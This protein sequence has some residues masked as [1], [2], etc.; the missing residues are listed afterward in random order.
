M[1]EEKKTE[2]EAP[3]ECGCECGCENE[4]GKNK[5]CCSEKDSK[6][7]K[8]I[9]SL[10]ILLGGL[11]I[12][13][14]FVDVAQM[15]RGSGFSTKNLNRSEIFQSEGKTWVAYSEPAVP[16][17]VIND[18]SC[19]KCDVSDALV[20]M[21]RIVPTISTEKVDYSSAKGKELI[22]KF[23][24]KTLPAFVFGSDVTKTDFYS[25]AQTLFTEK[26]NRFLLNSDQIG[27]PVGKYL[28]SP[29]VFDNDAISGPKDAKVKVVIFSDFQCPYCKVFFQNLR[30]VMGQ[31]QDNVLFDFKELPLDIHPQADNAA[32][33]SECALE[34]GKFWEY[35]DK[36]YAAQA[37]WGATKDTSK[38]KSYAVALKLDTAKF[39]SCLDSKKYKDKVA[40][41]VQQAAD[42]GLTGTPSIFVNNNFDSG[43]LTADQLKGMIDAELNK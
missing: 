8:N 7:M 22:Q 40:A 31:Y 9:I 30:T 32:L 35:A 23:G 39:N 13:S 24:I 28:E 29:A 6:K 26:D 11:F 27:L 37:E 5:K 34:Q 10:V 42:L 19:D 17:Q 38:F 18:D 36:L 16:V 2:S 41:D 15:V 14:L 12:G 21:R 1:E 4:D 33:A 20:W 25:Q 43:A 3:C